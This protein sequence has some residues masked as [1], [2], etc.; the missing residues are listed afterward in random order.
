ML[1]KKG[2]VEP[3]CMT[4]LG[5]IHQG[6]LSSTLTYPGLV[7]QY[8]TFDLRAHHE[9]FISKAPAAALLQ[10]RHRLSSGSLALHLRVGSCLTPTRSFCIFPSCRKHF[11]IFEQPCLPTSRQTNPLSLFFRARSGCPVPLQGRMVLR[12]LFPVL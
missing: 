1:Q 6:G 5:I 10:S 12:A 3:V 4:F 11:P 7:R 9:H 2:E 8:L